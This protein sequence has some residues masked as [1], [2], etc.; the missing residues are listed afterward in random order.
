MH[1]PSKLM[2]TSTS[3]AGSLM[4]AR[5]DSST[6]LPVKWLLI[7]SL[8]LFPLHKS[9]TLLLSSVSTLFEG[10]C[11][12]NKRNNPWTYDQNYR[13]RLD[14]ALGSKDQSIC[15]QAA[16]ARSIEVV[17][18]NMDRWVEEGDRDL[19]RA[20]VGLVGSS[21]IIFRWNVWNDNNFSFFL[22]LTLLCT[23]SQWPR[24]IK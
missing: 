20:W 16:G 2:C 23:T 10:E 7:P 3:F 21:R 14:G 8:R 5:F 19:R 6:I 1:T 4:T 11:W 17:S 12:N 24:F 15:S 22:L 13:C 9:N 18:G